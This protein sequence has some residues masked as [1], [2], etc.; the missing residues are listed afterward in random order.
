MHPRLLLALSLGLAAP[1]AVVAQSGTAAAAPPI[2]TPTAAIDGP[3]SDMETLVVSGVLPGPGMWK[4]SRGDNV[5]WVLG[6]L[7]PL[8]KKMEWVSKDVEAALAQSQ[9]IIWQPALSIN[10]DVG[11]FRGLMLVPK[12]LGARKNP[13][14]ATLKEVVPAD[15]Y[16]RWTPLKLKYVGRDAGIESWRPMFAAMKLYEEAMDDTGLVRSGI[17]GPVLQ[18]AVKRHRLT[19]T[20]PTVKL[21]ISD[22]KQALT[23]FRETRMDDLDCFRRTLDRIETDIDA[24]RERA[25]AWAVGDIDSLRALPYSDQNEACMRA[26]MESSAAQKRGARDFDAEMR[27]LWMEA[28]EKALAKNAV[29]FSVLPMREVLKAD[30][31]LAQLQAKGYT[32]EAP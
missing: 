1:F 30:G 14:G 5:M 20:A 4:V 2:A 29:T 13:D 3:I 17:V 8:P 26:A 27:K 16:A 7:S 32:V 10:A 24:M 19:E 9:E 18:R 6:T 28:A 11:M 23:E 12:A 22:P 31:Y 21:T 15:L 25:N